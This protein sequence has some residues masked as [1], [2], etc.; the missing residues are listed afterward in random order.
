MRK[1]L[2]TWILRSWLRIISL[3]DRN[4]FTAA[5]DQHN[6]NHCKAVISQVEYKLP[7]ALG[8]VRITIYTLP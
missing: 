4:N 1:S 5:R 2:V 6:N 7:P 8:L 3:S